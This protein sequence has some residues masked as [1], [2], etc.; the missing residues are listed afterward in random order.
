MRSLILGLGN[1]ILGDDAIGLVV[2]EALRPLVVAPD[3]EIDV[4]Y[5]GGLRLMER[6]VGYDRAIII[7]AICSGLNPPGTVLQLGPDDLPTH[8]SASAHDMTLPTA[9]RLASTL[10]LHMPQTIIIIAIEAEST[11]DL[12]ENLTPAVAAA[13]PQAANAVLACLAL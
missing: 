12:G 1:P 5:W 13:V 8:H 2:A 3:V 11:M 4:D 10:G 9:L 6:L 7:D